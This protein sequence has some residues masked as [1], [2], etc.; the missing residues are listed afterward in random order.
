M[1]LYWFG[2]QPIPAR[3]AHLHPPPKLLILRLFPEGQRAALGFILQPSFEL[4]AH[5][6]Q[7]S[8]LNVLLT[9]GN[10]DTSRNRP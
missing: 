1:L 7:T 10:N 8:L 6:L 2:T 9:Q 3:R 4:N 5:I